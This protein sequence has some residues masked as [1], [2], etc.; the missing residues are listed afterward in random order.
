[1]KYS[2]W[3][4]KTY[5]KLGESQ[6]N[7]RAL[8]TTETKAEG[9]TGVRMRLGGANSALCWNYRRIIAREFWSK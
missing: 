3:P 4:K 2:D 5:A 9:N 7:A 8:G 1:M 6:T